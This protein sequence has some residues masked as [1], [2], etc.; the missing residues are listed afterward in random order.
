LYEANIWLHRTPYT[1]PRTPPAGS[2]CSW[3][4]VARYGS[5]L[6][7]ADRTPGSRSWA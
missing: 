2:P 7:R 5:W 4:T 1:G 6:P 3:R